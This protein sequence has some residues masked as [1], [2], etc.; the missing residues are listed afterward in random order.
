MTEEYYID[1]S[2][3][4][5]DD[6]YQVG[7]SSDEEKRD[8]TFIKERRRVPEPILKDIYVSMEPNEVFQ[9]GHPNQKLAKVIE[10]VLEDRERL[11]ADVGKAYTSMIRTK[12]DYSK[13][14]KQ[15]AQV[16]SKLKQMKDNV[17]LITQQVDELQENQQEAIRQTHSDSEKLKHELKATREQITGQQDQLQV[18]Q[19]KIKNA[20]SKLQQFEQ[21]KEQVRA[22]QAKRERFASECKSQQELYEQQ[23]RSYESKLND[24]RSKQIEADMVRFIKELSTDILIALSLRNFNIHS[25]LRRHNSS[26]LVSCSALCINCERTVVSI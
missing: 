9:Y 11:I 26:K 8:E 21:L 19:D 7:E 16:T 14:K 12:K 25:R 13:E 18:V 2:A 3:D 6:T 24:L 15:V 10:K 1:S 20:N 5:N 17:T 22:A 4:D 23:V